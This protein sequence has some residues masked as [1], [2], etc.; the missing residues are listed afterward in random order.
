MQLVA[1]KV[2]RYKKLP[3]VL[4]YL[5]SFTSRVILPIAFACCSGCF[6]TESAQLHAAEELTSEGKP[7]EA[8]TAY[9]KH[10][11][12]RLETS[13]RP[14][15]ENPYFYLLNVG[16]IELSR[17]NVDAA[18]AAYEEAERENVELPLVADRYRAVAVW[19]E[20]HGEP[21]K[22]LDILTK[23]REKDPLIFDSMLDRIARELTKAE[24]TP[25]AR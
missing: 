19:Y 3:M 14:E 23:Y 15:W 6:S 20:E 1:R 5:R 16:D 9:R 18:L 24:T 7:D 17:G 4:L 13:D 25:D 22:A 11:S 21:Q 8:I 2:L 10:I 12:E